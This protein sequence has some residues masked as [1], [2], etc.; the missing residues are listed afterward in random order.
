MLRGGERLVGDLSDEE[1]GGFHVTP[2]H[3]L[4]RFVKSFLSI[5]LNI[6]YSQGSALK[7]LA[8]P[9]YGAGFDVVATLYLEASPHV[10]NSPL[11]H[12]DLF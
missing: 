6:L 7:E 9:P 12:L 8:S 11:R 4:T 2:P 3:R 5:V 10:Q 1:L